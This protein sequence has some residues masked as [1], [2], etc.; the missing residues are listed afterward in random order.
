MS[1]RIIPNSFQMPNFYCD[2]V[3]HLLNGA[4]LKVLIYAARRT[5]GFQSASARIS[6]TQFCEGKKGK[7]KVA[8]DHGTGLARGTVKTVL[9]LF[10][11]TGLLIQVADSVKNEGAEYALNLDPDKV[12][13]QPLL[14]RQAKDAAAIA[15]KITHLN[16]LRRAKRQAAAQEHAGGSS[17]EPLSSSTD[18]L[19]GSSTIEPLSS[20]MVEPQ[21]V[22][23]LNRRWFNERT[24]SGSMVEPPVLIHGK[25]EETQ[26][27]TQRERGARARLE[28]PAD[29][30]SDNA[31][32][33]ELTPIENALREAKGWPE[34]LS[35]R[36]F[37][38]MKTA[39]AAL[40]RYK[41]V[42]PAQIARVPEFYRAQKRVSWGLSWLV[43][44][45]PQ[46]VDWIQANESTGTKQ[47]QQ[48]DV[49]AGFRRRSL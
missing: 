40:A 30:F 25:P 4:E 21:V 33:P 39:A 3:M 38:E 23:P 1:N 16:D 18:E 43:N 41:T 45:W 2:E 34:C 29:C 14:D 13:L 27:E 22:Q 36:Q 19:P 48:S 17:V 32:T 37:Q 46:I 12:N 7:D 28:G 26:R 5:F 24:T 42:S 11:E 8:L 49:V 44:D 20:S 31:L 10:L 47:Q 35:P 15:P 9:K 6:L